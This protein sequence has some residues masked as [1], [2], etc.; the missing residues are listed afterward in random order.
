MGIGAKLL[1]EG[2]REVDRQGLQSM[3]GASPH[4]IGLYRKHGYVEFA[5]KEYKLWMY[6]GGEGLGTVKHVVMHR[7]ATTK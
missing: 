7:P 5:T 2:L 4:G 1:E 6:D 3:L